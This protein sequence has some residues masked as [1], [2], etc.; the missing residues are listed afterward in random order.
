MDEKTREQIRLDSIRAY[1]QFHLKNGDERSTLQSQ[2][3][4][5]LERIFNEYPQWH[6]Y[7]GFHDV[8][9]VLL[10]FYSLDNV[11]ERTVDICEGHLKDLLCDFEVVHKLIIVVL[12]IIR[13]ADPI[14]HEHITK[15]LIVPPFFMVS[16]L[17]TLF[18][19]DLHSLYAA[20]RILKFLSS[21]DPVMIL[22]MCAAVPL[23]MR[24]DVLSV[25]GNNGGEGEMYQMLKELPGRVPPTLLIW[26]AERLMDQIPLKSISES[27]SIIGTV[28]YKPKALFS[29][30]SDTGRI[31]FV[32]AAAAIVISIFISHLTNS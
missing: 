21:R 14:L 24:D 27:K 20:Q 29:S 18:A 10:T 23:L 30:F 16:W 28:Y 22:Y 25:N 31:L 8:C 3:Q 17:I 6:Y 7:Q 12:G 15:N 1:S 5:V 9:S 2:L 19:H 13:K 26:Q 32:G 11:L 4:I